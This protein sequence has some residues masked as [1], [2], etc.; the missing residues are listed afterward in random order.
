[1][2]VY[3]DNDYMCHTTNDGSLREFDVPDFEGK[4]AAYIE[5]CRYVPKG[6]SWTRDDGIVFQGEMISPA[7]DSRI[8]EAYQKQYEAM[9]PEMEDMKNALVNELGVNPNG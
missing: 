7:V 3:I 4:C 1:M 9:L 6:E 8:L 2:K 5:S